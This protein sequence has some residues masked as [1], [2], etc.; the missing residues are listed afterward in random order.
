MTPAFAAAGDLGLLGGFRWQDVLDIAIIAFLLYNALLL[1][2]GT[3][4]ASMIL[5]TIFIA[6]VYLGSRQLEL[7]TVSWIFDQFLTSIMIVLVVIFQ[8]DIRRMLTRVGRGSLFRGRSGAQ[9]S[10]MIEEI[11]R[12]VIS[13][14]SDKLGAIIAIQRDVG[15]NE[16]VEGG[17]RIDASVTRELLQSIFAGDSPLHDGAVI[18]NVNRIEAARCL[19]PLTTNPNVAKTLGTRHRAAIG[20]TEETDALAIVVSEEDR[21]ISLVVG[22]HITRGMDAAT[23]RTSLGQLV[24]E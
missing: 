15:L 18:I 21:S 5:G 1:I 6:L 17:A 23:L 7:Y 3:R 16:Y 4:S 20:L 13:L 8:H 9:T 2:R 24:E 11:T 14:A 22:G 19:L 10:Q 12:G